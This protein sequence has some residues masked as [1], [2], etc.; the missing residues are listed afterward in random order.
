MPILDTERLR[1]CALGFADAEFI[2]RLV[3]EPSWLANIGDRH[4]HDLEGARSYLRDGPLA[5]YER[6][7][8]GLYRI[9]RKID[10]ASLG[11]CGLLKRDYLEQADIGYAL[12]PEYCGQGYALEAAQAVLGYG[13][14]VLGLR[15]LAAIT[16]PDNRR[17][18]AL[19]D[20]LGLRWV[21]AMQL[22]GD[23]ELLSLYL[24]D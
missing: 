3:N 15:P 2:L 17:S 22:N 6:H 20:R 23:A 7:G 18:I 12:L 13:N 21:R 11:L 14:R 8:F 16:H 19:L 1:L 4:V 24:Q 9:E 10:G 5:M